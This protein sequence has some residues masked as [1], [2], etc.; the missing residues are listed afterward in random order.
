MSI[1]SERLKKLRE[2]KNWTQDELAQRLGVQRPTI[3][4]YESSEKNRIPRD[5]RLT[6]LA[7]LLG[8]S[9][10]YLLGVTDNRESQRAT[11]KEKLSK[12]GN[13]FVLKELVEKYKI[14]LTD[15]KNK[16]TLEKMIKLVYE[17]L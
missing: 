11:S 9:T 12:S 10:D 2:E 8:T 4:G 14:D 6:D 1:F 15:P 3:A 17:D 5:K 16:E 13:E 7:E